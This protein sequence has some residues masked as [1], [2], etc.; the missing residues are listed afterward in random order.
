MNITHKAVRP[1]NSTVHGPITSHG[2][3]FW[4]PICHNYVRPAAPG[5]DHEFIR[6]LAPGILRFIKYGHDDH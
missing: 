1:E 5:V 4:C 3:R 6:K 2:Y